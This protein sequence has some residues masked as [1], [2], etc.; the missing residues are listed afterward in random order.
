M[1]NQF[2]EKMEKHEAFTRWAVERGVKI[3]GIK[4][5]RFEGKGLGIIAEKR[6][7]VRQMLLCC[8][9]FCA[10]PSSIFIFIQ[11]I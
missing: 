6:L 7:G 2:L 8:V 11:T 3:N 5:Y 4:P 9:L 1:V 10:T